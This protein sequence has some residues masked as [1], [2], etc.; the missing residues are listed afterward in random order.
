MFHDANGKPK[1]P[2]PKFPETKVKEIEKIIENYEAEVNPGK[3]FIIAGSNKYSAWLDVLRA[4]SRRVER[5]V[6][7]FNRIHPLAKE[8]LAY[9]NRLSSLFFAMARVNAKR[10]DSKESNPRYK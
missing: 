2:A 4:I 8:I 3:G 7:K 5:S 6:L 1:Y 9:M 10:E